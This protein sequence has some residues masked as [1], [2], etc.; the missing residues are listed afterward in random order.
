MKNDFC[1]SDKN[2]T[3][4]K[5][6]I[7]TS[8]LIYKSSFGTFRKIHSKENIYA[9]FW[10]RSGDNLFFILFLF[11]VFSCVS[12]LCQKFITLTDNSE[13]FNPFFFKFPSKKLSV[14]SGLE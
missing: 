4:V 8:L 12:I 2:L 14:K 7:D 10:M 5:N 1:N 9:K 13:L 6:G 11:C 3:F